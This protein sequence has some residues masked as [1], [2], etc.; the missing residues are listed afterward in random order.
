MAAL[1]PSL[2]AMGG[3]S[4]RPLRGGIVGRMGEQV[5]A[6][7]EAQ[8][9]R[10]KEEVQEM[11]EETVKVGWRVR[12]GARGRRRCTGC[13]GKRGLE[14]GMSG[15]SPWLRVSPAQ[16]LYSCM[17][18]FTVLVP[19][20]GSAPSHSGDRADPGNHSYHIDTLTDRRYPRTGTVS[21]SWCA[22]AARYGTFRSAH[23]RPKARPFTSA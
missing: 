16:Q 17:Y 20:Q 21:P 13:F 9:Q 5:A 12:E 15:C 18:G 1:L 2:E 7:A 3:G 19:F 4:W 22:T 10:T 23:H 6:V 8:W 11:V 14:Y